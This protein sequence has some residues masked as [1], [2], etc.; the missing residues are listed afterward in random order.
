MEGCTYGDLSPLDFAGL[1]LWLR[2]TDGIE[3]QRANLVKRWNDISGNGIYLVGS[4]AAGGDRTAAGGIYTT[5]EGLAWSADSGDSLLR[6]S[7]STFYNFLINGSPYTLFLIYKIRDITAG[8]A[9]SN[10]RTVPSGT[11]PNVGW[12]QAN[13]ITSRHTNSANQSLYT[14]DVSSATAGLFVGQKVIQMET[15]YGYGSGQNPIAFLSLDGLTIKSQVSAY[16]NPPISG[17]SFQA[18]LALQSIGKRYSYEYIIYDHTGKTKSQID[19]EMS[20]LVNNYIKKR[21]SGF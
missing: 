10:I 13:G 7:N 4:D 17:D 11:N 14:L 19:S 6:F 3:Y 8:G 15:C 1:K 18:S 20:N 16:A 5:P 9:A 21:Y 12:S 2:A